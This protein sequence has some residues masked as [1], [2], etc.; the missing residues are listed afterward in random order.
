[1]DLPTHFRPKTTLT[2]TLGGYGTVVLKNGVYQSQMNNVPCYFTLTIKTDG[3]VEIS[4]P[5]AKNGGI[6]L[7]SDASSPRS[8]A[9]INVFANVFDVSVGFEAP[10]I[11]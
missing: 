9:T 3:T 7:T 11:T 1:M 10:A 8:F 2:M 6:Y 4:K 5:I